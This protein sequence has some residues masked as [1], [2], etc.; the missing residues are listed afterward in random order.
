MAAS[1]A[2]DDAGLRSQLERY[3][4]AGRHARLAERSPRGLVV[5]LDR[6]VDRA[7]VQ[8]TIAIEQQCCPW[9]SLRWQPDRRRL[10][11]SVSEARHEPA[12]DAIAF[13]LGLETSAQAPPG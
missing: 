4:Q 7:L 12:L 1:C 13:A 3:R 2:L 11:V 8:E 5:D 6:R 9:L 10:T